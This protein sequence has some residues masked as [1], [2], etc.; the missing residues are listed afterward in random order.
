MLPI[1]D[2]AICE[3]LKTSGRFLRAGS[4][5]RDQ[6]SIIYLWAV[7]GDRE[8]SMRTTTA[9]VSAVLLAGAAGIAFAQGSITQDPGSLAPRNLTLQDLGPSDPGVTIPGEPGTNGSRPLRLPNG[10]GAVATP[11]GYG[12]SGTGSRSGN[13][14]GGYWTSPLGGNR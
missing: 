13:V 14:G 3:R 11:P 10:R 7:R 1:A 12:S 6:L 4:A 5:Q 8:M 2:R 9:V